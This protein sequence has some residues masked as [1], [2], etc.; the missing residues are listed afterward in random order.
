MEKSK[1][2]IPRVQLGEEMTALDIMKEKLNIKV[3]IE[4]FKTKLENSQ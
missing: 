4:V 1:E 2:E 3:A